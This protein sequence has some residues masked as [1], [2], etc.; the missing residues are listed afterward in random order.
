MASYCKITLVGNVGGDPITKNFDGGKKL[1]EFS[2]AVND[3]VNKDEKPTWYRVSVWNN[4]ADTILSYVKKGDTIL[5]E[6]RLNV[7]NY[8]DNDGRER[9]SLEVTA[10]DFLLLG[11]RDPGGAGSGTGQSYP[12]TQVTNPIDM[13]MEAAAQAPATTNPDYLKP[14]EPSDVDDLP[15]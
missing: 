13:P 11:R 5:V 2:I 10:D 3:R 14:T 8:L 6:G 1:A 4:R 7:R 9:Y 15:F 12:T